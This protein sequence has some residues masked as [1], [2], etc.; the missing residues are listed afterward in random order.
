MHRWG[1]S[2]IPLGL[3]TATATSGGVAITD[4]RVKRL[5]IK[6]SMHKDFEF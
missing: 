6:T 1:N 4:E 2:N 5:A 3:A